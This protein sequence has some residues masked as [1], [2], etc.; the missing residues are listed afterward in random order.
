MGY[1][2]LYWGPS[3]WQLFHLIAF[4]SP[5]PQQILLEMKEILPCKFCRASTKDFVAQHPL[6]GDPGK[7]LYEIHNM[8]NQGFKG[9]IVLDAVLLP[10]T[11]HDRSGPH[12]RHPEASVVR[13]LLHLLQKL[14]VD[15]DSYY[16]VT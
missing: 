1:N 16:I 11:N 12:Q 7:W 14:K 3:G 5:N 13:F 10:G 8:V 9:L 6:K 4:L 15:F 2:T